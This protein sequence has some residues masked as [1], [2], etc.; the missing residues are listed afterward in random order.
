M[1]VMAYG[2]QNVVSKKAHQDFKFL[3]YSHTDILLMF[4]RFGDGEAAHNPIGKGWW[5]SED[6]PPENPRMG[7][8]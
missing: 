3:E 7:M 1:A 8:S 6:Q 5:E 2:M 4:L